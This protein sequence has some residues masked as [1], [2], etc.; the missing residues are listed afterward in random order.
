ML[1]LVHLPRLKSITRATTCVTEQVH[2]RHECAAAGVIVVHDENFEGHAR[3]DAAP[4]L[5]NRQ[6]WLRGRR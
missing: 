3:S 2:C 1:L 4:R 5:A 6:N